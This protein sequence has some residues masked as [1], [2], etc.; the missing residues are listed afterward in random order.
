[1]LV[2][3]SLTDKHRILNVNVD[4][5]AMANTRVADVYK[6]RHL[7]FFVLHMAGNKNTNA[8]YI[9]NAQLKAAP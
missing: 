7:M 8:C 4:A 5:M 9:N 3:R 1:M 2:G 6:G